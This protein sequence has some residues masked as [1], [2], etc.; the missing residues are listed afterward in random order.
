MRCAKEHDWRKNL[1]DFK[2][3]YLKREVPQVLEALEDRIY[4]MALQGIKLSTIAALYNVPFGE[5]R[6]VSGEVWRCGNTDLIA[7]IAAQSN[8]STNW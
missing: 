1:R 5:F 4:A 7:R 3:A 8:P 6:E 2:A